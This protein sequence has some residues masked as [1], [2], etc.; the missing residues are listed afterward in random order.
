MACDEGKGMMETLKHWQSEVM[1]SSYQRLPVHALFQVEP[2]PS[3][4]YLALVND[5]QECAEWWVIWSSMKS[6]VRG[7]G[8]GGFKG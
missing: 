6:L 8:G 3:L 5:H 4:P 7:G 2:P 1:M